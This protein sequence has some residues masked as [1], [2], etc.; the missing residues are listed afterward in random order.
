MLIKILKYFISKGKME[1]KQ[2]KKIGKVTVLTVI[3]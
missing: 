2:E 1:R 3:F